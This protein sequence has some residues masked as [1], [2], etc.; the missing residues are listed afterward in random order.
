MSG[1]DL[2]DRVLRAFEGQATIALPH[3]APLIPMDLKT[4][5]KH[6]ELGNLPVHIKGT[7]LARRHYVC[8][9][10][11]VEEFFR[12][13]G[14]ACPSSRSEIPR[15]TNSTSKSRVYDFPAQRNAGM[16]VTQR[17]SRKRAGSKL[18]GS[19][20]TTSGQDASR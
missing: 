12:R 13:T 10:N 5:R 15:T 4:L 18:I 19:L 14:E 11:D 16:N 20:P 3:L 6:R 1:V 7:G 17:K 8:T 2:P 9:L